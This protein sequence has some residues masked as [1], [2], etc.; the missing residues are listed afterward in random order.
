MEFCGALSLFFSLGQDFT[1]EGCPH[2]RTKLKTFFLPLSA[3]LLISKVLLLFLLKKILFPFVIVKLVFCLQ[4]V[5][6]KRYL[7][8]IFIDVFSLEKKLIFPI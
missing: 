2:S 7:S 6:E 4:N 8:D 5:K 1:F 3:L